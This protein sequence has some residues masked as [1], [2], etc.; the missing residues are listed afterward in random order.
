MQLLRFAQQTSIEGEAFKLKC[1]SG[2]ETLDKIFSF[3]KPA[4]QQQPAFFQ[5]LHYYHLPAE[6]A[7][8]EAVSSIARPSMPSKLRFASKASR[9]PSL[10][11]SMDCR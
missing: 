11:W 8:L 6:S 2:A 5:K 7:E 9:E 4:P 3:K 1:R 10:A